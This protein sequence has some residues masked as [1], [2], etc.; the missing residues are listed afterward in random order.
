MTVLMSVG[1]FTEH[2]ARNMRKRWIIALALV[3]AMAGYGLWWGNRGFPAE[4]RLI[5]KGMTQSQV[6]ALVGGHG[7]HLL[8]GFM[9]KE[10]YHPAI[11][12]SAHEY[13]LN[14]VYSMPGMGGA[15]P[16]MV[17]CLWVT[18]RNRAM[19]WLRSLWSMPQVATTLDDSM[20]YSLN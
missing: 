7:G 18:K 16:Q 12:A 11:F 15:E 13:D 20:V 19:E 6:D 14:I 17:V 5:A 9:G 10:R 3:A 1:S 8:C 4:W 2:P